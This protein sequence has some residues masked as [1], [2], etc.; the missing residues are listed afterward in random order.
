MMPLYF[1]FGLKE[2]F[3]FSF[4]FSIGLGPQNAV[5]VGRDTPRAEP[6]KVCSVSFIV[7]SEPI[8]G[9]C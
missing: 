1:S 9:T 3:A 2:Y 6:L 4:T 8:R 5:D 7:I